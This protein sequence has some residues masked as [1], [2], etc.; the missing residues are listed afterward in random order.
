MAPYNPVSLFAKPGQAQCQV[1]T[2]NM[3][4]RQTYRHTDRIYN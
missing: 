2:N 4:N 3:V 1:G